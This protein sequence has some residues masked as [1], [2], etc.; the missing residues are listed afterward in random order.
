VIRATL[1]A[2][3]L[4]TPALADLPPEVAAAVDTC[5]AV[6][7]D[8]ETRLA[9]LAATGW[10]RP[11]DTEVDDVALALASFAMVQR[12]HV[13]PD[14][15]L[16]ERADAFGRGAEMMMRNIAMNRHGEAFLLAPSGAA[17]QIG[18]SGEGAFCS[19]AADATAADLAAHL[20]LP[21][22]STDHG[23]IVSTRIATDADSPDRTYHDEFVPGT[24][25]A[26]NILPMILIAPTRVSE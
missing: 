7:P 22:E 26:A 13:R 19:L 11:A 14:Q 3:C 12:A 2:A 5:R 1:L 16:F 21:S 23:F 15:T 4:A 9:S 10:H 25:G 20:G 8:L 24:F 17:L 6:G 18:V